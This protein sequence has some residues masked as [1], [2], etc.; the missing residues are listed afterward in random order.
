M[1]NP[2]RVQQQQQRLPAAAQARGGKLAVHCRASRREIVHIAGSAT[3][4]LA[5]N[6]LPALADVEPGLQEVQAV[7]AAAGAEVASSSTSTQAA[8]SGSKQVR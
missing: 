2:V 7:P 1:N 8:P 6:V 3:L 5:G 4:L